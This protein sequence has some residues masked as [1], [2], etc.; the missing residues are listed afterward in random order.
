M[1]GKILSRTTAILTVF[2]FL[3]ISVGFTPA[4]AEYNLE[5]TINTALREIRD[6]HP[7]QAVK[8]LLP[9]ES[10]FPDSSILQE[11]LGQSYELL[12]QWENSLIHY[13]KASDLNPSNADLYVARGRIYSTLSNCDDAI[14]LF[15]RALELDPDSPTIHNYLGQ[16]Y[17]A[18]S[19]Y[20][21][22]VEHY[23][24][25]TKLDGSLAASRENLG[26]V[27]LKMMKYE[28]AA[29]ALRTA[30]SLN[31][32]S[33]NTFNNL[34]FAYYK[35]K[36]YDA[37]LAALDDGLAHNPQSEI[38]RQNRAFL[39]KEMEQIGLQV[40]QAPLPPPAFPMNSPKPADAGK[41]LPGQGTLIAENQLPGS[42]EITRAT[43]QPKPNPPPQKPTLI[44]FSGER[45]EKVSLPPLEGGLVPLPIPSSSLSDTMFRFDDSF[46]N[47]QPYDPIA[48]AEARKKIPGTLIFEDNNNNLWRIRPAT[49]GP[50]QM[51]AGAQPAG[52]RD[53]ARIVYLG[54]ESNSFKLYLY[55]FR[56]S[57]RTTLYSSANPLTMPAFAPD[58]T[59]V[60]FAA[61]LSAGS[62]SSLLLAD[63]K[64]H[65]I[66]RIVNDV[67]FTGYTWN[68]N[69]YSIWLT[70]RG[71]PD[72]IAYKDGFCY[73]RIDPRSGNIEYKSMPLKEPSGGKLYLGDIR[74]TA[75][76]FS[77]DGARLIVYD[78]SAL[79]DTFYVI[80]LN[81][82]KAEIKNLTRTDGAKMRVR[83][84]EWGYN[85]DSFS[86]NYLGN[87]WVLTPDSDKPFPAVTD[88]FVN[89]PAVWIP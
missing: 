15:K 73:A 63:L 84:I 87:I 74:K 8:Y 7:D 77:P 41:K 76:V 34:S 71:C 69:D 19:Q 61:I 26:S 2:L 37:A 58:G 20:D 78:N 21:L 85:K 88:H 36:R 50:R 83:N 66:L 52:D 5:Q 24:R 62:P 43:A 30:A 22:A 46:P 35:L 47:S 27:Y 11:I 60:A 86:F 79:T 80:D 1:N 75:A 56:T 42:D 40:A 32:L 14:A 54:F 70:F 55:D 65:E 29:A 3:A 82:G 89:G 48:L 28:E 13:Q 23:L 18:D 51:F 4:R 10:Q 12:G 25:A 17:E 72:Q 39:A 49:S 59:A 33:E 45:N 31:P 68:P 53:G 9:L 6:S 64:T 44:K 38:L 57:V 67:A 16:S 81:S